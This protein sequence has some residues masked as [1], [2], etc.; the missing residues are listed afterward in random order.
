M[1][2]KKN[3]NSEKDKATEDNTNKGN[4]EN[5]NMPEWA[6]LLL[7]G[8][9]AMGGNYMLFI[10]PLQE[11]FDA[12]NLLIGKQEERID[13][14]EEQQEKIINKLNAE[15]LEKENRKGNGDEYFKV[16]KIGGKEE[17]KFKYRNVNL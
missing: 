12:M 4:A 15:T 6:K 1:E 10:K 5:A 13:E 17:E 7:T 11:K 16:K 9:G 14:L 2:E 3:N 8:V